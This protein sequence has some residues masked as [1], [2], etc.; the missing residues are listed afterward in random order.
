MANDDLINILVVD[1]HEVVRRGLAVFLRAFDDLHLIGEAANGLEAI[2]QCARLHPHVI[3]MDLMMPEMDG[4]QAIRAI[5]N[6]WPEV[7][8]IGLTSF[9]EERLGQQALQAGAVK[10]LRKDTS[11]DDLAD[12]IRSAWYDRRS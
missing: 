12:A 2:D 10:C 9:K 4:I 3:L 7:Q 5:I 6:E 11:I 8:I 1:D